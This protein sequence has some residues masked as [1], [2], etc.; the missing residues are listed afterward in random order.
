MRWRW[1]TIGGAHLGDI[2]AQ[3]GGG[4]RSGGL[5]KPSSLDALVCQTSWN[6]F[7][8]RLIFWKWSELH[9]LKIWVPGNFIGNLETDRC[10]AVWILED[11]SIVTQPDMTR[12]MCSSDIIEQLYK[13]CIIFCWEYPRLR[14]QCG[15][16]AVEKQEKRVP[17]QE[18]FQ[19][20]DAPAM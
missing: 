2:G 15:A 17:P 20:E 8:Q 14:W 6:S 7:K 12:K 1:R 11:K 9:F 19:E 16:S 10:R 5:W 13:S 4:A 3:S 18:T